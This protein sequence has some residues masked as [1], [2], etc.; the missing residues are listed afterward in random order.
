MTHAVLFTNPDGQLTGFSV[1]GHSGYAEEG[2]DIVCA[3]IS[4]LT[5]TCINAMESV[6]GV[7]PTVKGGQN[8]RLEMHL[9]SSLSGQYLHDAQILLKAL[10]QGFS[11]ISEAY[12]KY[13][14]FSIME[15][16]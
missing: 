5:I 7:H 3:G 8:G 14:E 9:P 4:I 6:A 16:R 1:K 10:Q 12:P 11:D 15:R 2:K 13:F